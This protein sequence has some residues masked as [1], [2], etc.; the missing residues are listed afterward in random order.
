MPH[1]ARDCIHVPLAM[2]DDGL[3]Y[4]ARACGMN[5]ANKQVVLVTSPEIFDVFTKGLMPSIGL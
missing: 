2:R 4:R 3:A 1:V 5:S